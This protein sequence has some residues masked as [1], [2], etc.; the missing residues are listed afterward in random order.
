[1]KEYKIIQLSHPGKEY[2]GYSKSTGQFVKSSVGINWSSDFSS[3][4]RGWNNLDQQKGNLYFQKVQS[5]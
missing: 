5:T 2:P 4:T 1:M 3:G